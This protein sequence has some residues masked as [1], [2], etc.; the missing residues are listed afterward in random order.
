MCSNN[1]FMEGM[2]DKQ[3]AVYDVEAQ[4]EEIEEED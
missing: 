2:L 3:C 1:S 4:Q